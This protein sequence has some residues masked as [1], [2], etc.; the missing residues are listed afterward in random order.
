[1]IAVFEPDAVE[2]VTRVLTD[3]GE[4]VTMLGEV[5]PAHGERRVVYNGHLDL[6]W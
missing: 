1:M 3:A 6:S 5:V 4:S 2:A